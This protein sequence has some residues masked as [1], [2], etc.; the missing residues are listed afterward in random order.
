MPSNSQESCRNRKR[1]TVFS[2]NT[3]WQRGSVFD[4]NTDPLVFWCLPHV[5][6][7]CWHPPRVQATHRQ[8]ENRMGRLISLET[9]VA[10]KFDEH[11]R[12]GTIRN[13]C[14]EGV[15]PFCRI[16]SRILFDEDD[17]DAWIADH[18]TRSEATRDARRRRTVRAT[19]LHAIEA[20]AH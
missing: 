1:L 8:E 18:R 4:M 2:I 7:I 12:P 11:I 6:L 3:L 20:T 5:P 17:I 19:P 13:W 14:S 15:I 9:L 16:G 10:E